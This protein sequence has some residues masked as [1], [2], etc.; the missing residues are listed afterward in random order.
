SV[1]LGM[2]RMVEQSRFRAVSERRAQERDRH[3]ERFLSECGDK[4][5]VLVEDSSLL[6]GMDLALAKGGLP[7]A[8]EYFGY[9]A[10]A[11]SEVNAVWIYQPGGE[12]FYSINNRYSPVL[13]KL[14]LT[15]GQLEEMF[16][17]NSVCHFFIQVPQGWMEVR[18]ATVHQSIDR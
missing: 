5:K 8:T 3:F 6:D 14:P 16:A 7:W 9:Q 15:P 17:T 2:L 13:E 4:L 1:G 10:L 18:G 12:L 11:T